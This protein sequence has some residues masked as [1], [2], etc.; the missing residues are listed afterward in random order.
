MSFTELIEL[1]GGP[2]ALEELG[3][4]PVPR[5]PPPTSSHSRSG[6]AQASS[7]RDAEEDDDED[8]PEQEE[9]EREQQETDSTSRRSRRGASRPQDPPE[10]ELRRRRIASLALTRKAAAE[11]S[12]TLEISEDELASPVKA[13]PAT[14]RT[15]SKPLKQAAM[16][17]YKGQS[18]SG[19]SY[20]S[21]D[22]LV[23]SDLQPPPRQSRK[24]RAS[25]Q[26]RGS[27]RG[28]RR[29]VDGSDYEDDESATRKSSRVKRRGMYTEP[30]IND[31]FYLEA[32]ATP[33]PTR[34]RVVHSK[35]IFPFIEPKTSFGRK[36]T[37]LCETCGT[38]GPSRA[39]GNLVYC[40]GCSSSFHIECMGNRTTRLHLVTKTADDDFVM[41]CKRCTNLARKKDPTA[42]DTAACQVCHE[43]GEA[44]TPFSTSSLKKK[45]SAETTPDA[46]V[47]PDLL[48]NPSL[49]LFRCLHCK[50]AWHTSHLDDDEADTRAFRCGECAT[51][52]LKIQT[53]RA[54]RPTGGAPTDPAPT[55]LDITDYDEDSR[56]YLIKF[57]GTSYFRAEW[58]PGAWVWGVNIH[59][60]GHFVK[61]NPLLAW[62][63]EQAVPESMFRIETVYDVRYTSFVPTGRERDVDVARIGEVCEAFVKWQ[64][65]EGGEAEWEV[66]PAEPKGLRRRRAKRIFD[67]DAGE[68]ADGEKNEEDGEKE[69]EEEEEAEAESTEVG[70]WEDWRKAYEDFVAG[71]YV[72][73]PK[74]TTKRREMVRGK[75]FKTF[76]KKEQ[77]SYIVGGKLMKY[78]M[79]GMK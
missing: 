21:E 79:D 3:D 26:P 64:G 14:R 76:E 72:H 51:H 29:Q 49:V 25:Q 38:S 41:Q 65:G 47:D 36:H 32:D 57:H 69:E 50:R 66:P 63:T 2:E 48:Y 4:E 56:E 53:I 68:D 12:P 15:R 35:E 58:L 33:Q 1:E 42:P 60:R 19:P 31:D 54:W 52:T 39:R 45:D 18:H 34:T 43:Q 62:T 8:K 77:P 73:L 11:R 22:D 20:D 46:D 71:H 67:L 13:G 27:A 16:L 55:H 61:K 74:N 37:Q 9:D 75:N 24:R 23:V 78:Q 28:K 10:R 44:C 17:P 70:R 40:Q 30:D 6:R 59:M 7:Y 5:P